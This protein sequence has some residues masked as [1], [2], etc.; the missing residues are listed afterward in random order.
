MMV[1]STLKIHSGVDFFML[2]QEMRLV[3]L[4]AFPPDVAHMI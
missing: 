4:A 3:E 1:K 2:N